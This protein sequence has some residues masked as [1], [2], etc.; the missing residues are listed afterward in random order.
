MSYAS[1]VLRRCL[2]ALAVVAGTVVACSSLPDLTFGDGDAGGSEGGNPEASAAE[3][4]GGEG[5]VDAGRDTSPP[6]VKSGAEVCDD[7]LD[8][9]C[10]GMFDCADPACGAGYAC[11]DAPPSGWQ[12]V[13]FAAATRPACPSSFGAATD[14]SAV[15]GNSGGTCGCACSPS[16]GSTACN[17]AAVMAIS[18]DQAACTGGVTDVRTVN[19]NMACTALSSP[20]G[21]PNGT[22]FVR[23]TTPPPPAACD[24]AT[25]LA[26]AP[27]TDGRTC[28]P[29]TRFG[30]GCA[31]GQVCA[32]KPTG[33]AACAAKTG[34]DVC[35]STYP[36]RSSAGTAPIDTRACNTCNCAPQASCPVGTMT[37]YTAADCTTAGNDK[38]VAFTATCAAPSSKSTL[39]AYKSALAGTGCASVGFNPASTGGITWTAEETV[40]CK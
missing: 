23:S 3:G 40:C 19:T 28:A 30:T 31:G 1:P 10:N 7:G 12:L 24:S 25:T 27:I 13:A 5:G 14:L 33:M 6:C 9:D 17:A 21:I 18:S 29:P 20:L 36:K 35:P 16:F 39:L 22:A 8:N 32:P 11:T 26:V 37:L 2:L 38:A 4:G 34:V 15:A